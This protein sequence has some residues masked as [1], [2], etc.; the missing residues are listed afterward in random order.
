MPAITTTAIIRS[1][2]DIRTAAEDVV[3]QEEPLEIRVSLPSAGG[4]VQR[5]VSVTMRT[6]GNDTDLAVGFLFTEGI[7]SLSLIHI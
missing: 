3:V 5:N 6:P 4:A 1:E 7:I 2:G